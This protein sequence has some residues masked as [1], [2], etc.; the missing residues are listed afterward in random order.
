MS[1]TSRSGNLSSL[2]DIDFYEISIIEPSEISISFDSPTNSNSINYY[3][4]SILDSY[5]SII[6][7]KKSGQD[8]ELKASANEIGNYFVKVKPENLNTNQYLISSS[9]TKI[10]SSISIIDEDN[11]FEDSA[12]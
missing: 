8:F 6:G 3:N 2:S 7:T 1:G 10:D 5:G 4:V 11:V 12:L 9:T